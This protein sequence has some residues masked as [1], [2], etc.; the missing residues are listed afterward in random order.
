MSGL[1]RKHEDGRDLSQLY[2]ELSSKRK[3]KRE[4]A[5]QP[6]K[7]LVEPRIQDNFLVTS[8]PDSNVTNQP[9]AQLEVGQSCDISAKPTKEAI[10]TNNVVNWE[11]VMLDIQH[12]DPNKVKLEPI[13]FLLVCRLA[14]CIPSNVDMEIIK[15]ELRK[16]GVETDE[17][18]LRL[19]GTS[20]GVGW[21]PRDMCTALAIWRRN[22]LTDEFDVPL[23]LFPRSASNTGVVSDRQKTVVSNSLAIKYLPEYQVNH[24]PPNE[25]PVRRPPKNFVPASLDVPLPCCSRIQ[26]NVESNSATPRKPTDIQNLGSQAHSRSKRKREEGE[27]AMA[28]LRDQLHGKIPRKY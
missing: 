11:T 1:D 5:T 6:S 28:G 2:L 23:L 8:H 9:A 15:E 13:S 27:E 16:Q 10:R 12:L 21:N 14:A 22:R 26:S 18:L 7:P 20:K 19:K 17:Y 25:S 4:D 3:A 24:P